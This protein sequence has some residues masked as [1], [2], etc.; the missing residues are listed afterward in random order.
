MAY[1]QLPIVEV[2]LSRLLLDLE[3]YRIPTRRDDEAGALKYLF[4]S[5]DVLGAARLILRDGYFD[6]EV[7]IVIAAESRDEPPSYIVLEG[8]R[9]VSALKA[10][11]DPTIVPGHEAEVRSLLKRYAVEAENLPERIRVIVAPDRATAAPHVARLHTGISKK[12]W[13]RDQQATFYYSL[14]DDQTTVEDVKAQYPDVEVAR[15]MKMAVMRRFLAAAPFSDH[16]LRQY[17]ASDDLAMSAFEYAYRSKDI[18]AAIGVEFDRDGMLLPRSSTPEKIASK[19]PKKKLGAL[20]YLVGEFR[21]GRLNTRSPELKKRDDAYQPFVDRLNGVPTT[22]TP[23]PSPA[24]PAPPTPPGPSQGVSHGMPPSGPGSATGGATPPQPEPPSGAGSRGPNHPDTKD[25]LDL[26]GLDYENAP[27]NL[28][29]RYFE[30][31][32][33]NLG[34]LPIASAILLRSVLEATIKVHFEGSA[35]PATGE[36][37]AVFKVVAQTYGSEK[38]LKSTIGA[39]QSGNAHKH[40]SIQWF[41]LIA[42]SADAS[43]TAEDVRQAWKVVNP[44][45]RRLLR[46][47]LQSAPATP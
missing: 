25:T 26:S 42:H 3:N 45:L 10:L 12:R 5:E 35:T 24:A 47:P 20:E 2:E 13:S 33:I 40:G 16:T 28:K 44:L 7:P 9:R 14:V 17:A 11:Y 31:R 21:A 43:V 37:S 18:A 38:T 30:L 19:L 39:I 1:E 29:L 4:A 32:R 34:N 46:P 41:N 22:A 6:N 23:T 36:L 27:L 8:N 15:F